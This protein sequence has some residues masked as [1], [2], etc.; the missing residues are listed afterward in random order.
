[1]RYFCGMDV[2]ISTARAMELQCVKFK[3][4]DRGEVLRIF[5]RVPIQGAHIAFYRLFAVLVASTPR[6]H[7]C[8]FPKR[9]GSGPVPAATFS[10][11]LSYVAAP[12]V[13][14]FGTNF[15][16]RFL[17][18]GSITAAYSSR[19]PL[20]LVVRLSNHVS[21]SFVHEHYLDVL[22]PPSPVLRVFSGQLT[23]RAAPNNK[24]VVS[25]VWQPYAAR[26][27]Y[28]MVS[29]DHSANVPQPTRSAQIRF[30][31]QRSPL[32]ARTCTRRYATQATSPRLGDA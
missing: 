22:D 32:S 5:I 13:A 2:N 10:A 15:T 7:S 12:A 28:G 27:N 17:L 9:D 21:E 8:L 24:E 11:A 31:P 20:P 26:A 25:P 23:D 14:P 19:V 3:Y 1:M 29:A 16:L 30:V 18:C 4:T 6:N